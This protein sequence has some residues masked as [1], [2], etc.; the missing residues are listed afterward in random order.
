MIDESQF[1][2]IKVDN[3]IA[4]TLIFNVYSNKQGY[5]GETM[6]ISLYATQNTRNT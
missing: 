6:T 4:T 3:K 1:K 5:S 2:K